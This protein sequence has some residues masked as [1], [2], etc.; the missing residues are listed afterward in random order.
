MRRTLKEN[1]IWK[2]KTLEF[3]GRVNFFRNLHGVE[4][5]YRTTGKGETE[6]NEIDSS[7]RL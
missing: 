6:L 7:L 5:V 4:A 3:W 2:S 1:V